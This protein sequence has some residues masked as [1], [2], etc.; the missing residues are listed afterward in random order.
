MLQLNNEFLLNLNNLSNSGLFALINDFDRKVYV[1]YSRNIL[2]AL[3][4][5]VS[6]L[7]DN[8]KTHKNIKEDFTKLRLVVLEK[9]TDV[10]LMKILYNNYIE[11]YRNIGYTSYRNVIPIKLRVR[12]EITLDYKILVHLVCNN[13]TKIVVG[14]FDKM[15]EADSFVADF[16]TDR[17]IKLVYA[18]NALTRNY[19]SGISYSY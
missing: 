15:K 9:M 4:R 12:I 16:Y 14:V 6:D 19:Y 11:H 8:L 10:R 3:K 18:N 17:K 5:I 1:G 13:K 2:D 7:N